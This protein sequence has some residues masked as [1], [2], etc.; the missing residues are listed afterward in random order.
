MEVM[1]VTKHEVWPALRKQLVT[2]DWRFNVHKPVTREA[3]SW[4]LGATVPCASCNKHVPVVRISKNGAWYLAVTCP[5]TRSIACARSSAARVE[6]N[7]I[8]RALAR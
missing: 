4:L 7:R 3:C 2:H 8:R 5:L 1:S 6:T